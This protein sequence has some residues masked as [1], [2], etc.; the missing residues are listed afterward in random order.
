MDALRLPPRR[1]A[2]LLFAALLAIAAAEPAAGRDAAG[3]YN[4]RPSPDTRFVY[5]STSGD[6]RANGRGEN[7]PL[8]TLERAKKQLRDG[9]PDH[10]LIRAGDRFDEP[11]G[12]FAKSGRSAD[13]PMFVG[14]YGEGDRPEFN[15]GLLAHAATGVSHLVI[16]GLAF[17]DRSR[18]PADP[19]FSVEAARRG[20]YGIKW[21]E[22]GENVLFEDLKIS[23]FFVGMDLS[24]DAGDKPDDEEIRA[25]Q[26][27]G[28]HPLRDVT[29]RRCIVVDNYGVNGHAQ[30]LFASNLDGLRVEECTFDRNG[31][32]EAVEGSK[33][34]IFKHNV[35]QYFTLNSRMELVGNL[36][37]RPSAQGAQVRGGGLVEGNFFGRCPIA[38]TILDGES[39]VAGN[40]VLDASDIAGVQENGFGFLVESVA[41]IELT[42]NLF[43]HKNSGSGHGVAVKVS[44]KWD[45]HGRDPWRERIG[46]P[47]LSATITGNLVS[48]WP[49]ASKWPAFDVNEDQVDAVVTGNRVDPAGA[50]VP[51]LADYMAANGRGGGDPYEALAEEAANRP[52]GTW[53]PRWTAAGVNAFL[54]AG[55]GLDEAAPAAGR[56]PSHR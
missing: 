17:R 48:D 27:A 1:L 24:G 53:D 28:K 3:F 11:F 40:A 13:Q 36:I 12:Y 39:R 15:G 41:S 46:N 6:D 51:T 23:R 21:N 49:T 30:G 14:V 26:R 4:P 33:P 55:A 47:Q 52:R 16:Q 35:Y 20:G 50:A 18:D 44:Q 43:A 8:R 34:D 45:H 2:F 10:L 31:H 22:R 42:G 32:D 29:V 54:R 7:T 5:V 56:D 38:M 37:T 25:R 19:S 9:F